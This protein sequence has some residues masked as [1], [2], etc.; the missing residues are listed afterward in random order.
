MLCSAFIFCIGLFFSS[1]GFS[2]LTVAP[3][4]ATTT[5]FGAQAKSNAE[6][7]TVLITGYIDIVSGCSHAKGAAIPALDVKRCTSGGAGSINR[8]W[9][10]C[11][12][13]AEGI[14][15][16]R[17]YAVDVLTARHCIEPTTEDNYGEGTLLSPEKDTIAIRF[18][19][20]STGQFDGAFSPTN[21]YD[22]ELIRVRAQ[23]V[24]VGIAQPNFAIAP[25]QPL[26]VLGHSR[27]SDW[28]WK[29]AKSVD[30]TQASL[31]AG[32]AYTS[33]IECPQCAEGDSG[34]GVWSNDG[35]LVGIFNAMTAQ[36]GFFT[37]ST[38]ITGLLPVAR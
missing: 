19:D 21:S 31:I 10:R 4:A 18:H 26:H 7:A 22:V 32:W 5:T 37:A 20:G 33:M 1:I 38:R 35:K 17:G 29:P 23:R 25:D 36:Y 8:V 13:V 15:D 11:A 14:E 9:Y 3:A 28:G 34:G 2:T 27:N 30:G 16:A 24:H 6:N 12:G